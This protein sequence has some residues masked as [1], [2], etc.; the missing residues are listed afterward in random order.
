ML[1]SRWEGAP[2]TIIEAQRLGCVP[3]ATD[4]GAV[5]ELIENKV[6]GLLLRSSDDGV[7][8]HDLI[9]ALET[10][11]KSE[12]LL[13]NPFDQC[14]T[15]Q[16]RAQLGK[17]LQPFLRQLHN[18]F[19]DRLQSIRRTK[20]PVAQISSSSETTVRGSAADGATLWQQRGR[21]TSVR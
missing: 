19:P 20:A 14:V 8:T 6:D 17:E 1:P 13:S 21:Q 9:T 4:V 15:A 12:R 18:W 11:A 7:V 2:L 5:S 3:V 10:L 16:C